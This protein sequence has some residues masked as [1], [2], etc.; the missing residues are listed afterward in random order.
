MQRPVVTL[1]CFYLAG[2]IL[3]Q[4]LGYFPLSLLTFLCL[5]LFLEKWLI[6]CGRSLPNSTFYF[7]VLLASMVYVYIDS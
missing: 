3:G 4:G 5:G 7:A 1:A 6:R 2:L